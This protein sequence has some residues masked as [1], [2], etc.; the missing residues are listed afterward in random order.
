AQG[1]V[2]SR[3]LFALGVRSGLARAALPGERDAGEDRPPARPAGQLGPGG[4]AP[5]R[6]WRAA[7]QAPGR[8]SPPA[9]GGAAPRL[10][11]RRGPR[12]PRPVR[13]PAVRGQGRP[14]GGRRPTRRRRQVKIAPLLSLA[15]LACHAS[16]APD[17]WVT[18]RRD[19]L[20]LGVD[21]SGTLKSVDSDSLGPP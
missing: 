11:A 6:G 20:V 4:R 5:P 10:D 7:A 16:A 1:L 3:V 2:V 19:D 12:G 21:I 8:W 9:R 17:A 13:R 18:T 15:A 14:G